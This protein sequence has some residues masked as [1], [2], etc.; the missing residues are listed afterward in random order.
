[1]YEV[2]MGAM[3]GMLG[4]WWCNVSSRDVCVGP[5]K[6]TYGLR[7]FLCGSLYGPLMGSRKHKLIDHQLYHVGLG[8]CSVVCFRKFMNVNLIVL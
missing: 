3:W 8:Q 5:G 2:L 6:V 1:M 4:P 7:G